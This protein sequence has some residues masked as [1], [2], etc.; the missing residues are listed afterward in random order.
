MRPSVWLPLSKP[1]QPVSGETLY[2]WENLKCHSSICTR[3]TASFPPSAVPPSHSTP[4]IFFTLFLFQSL[5]VPPPPPT[6]LPI[7]SQPLTSIKFLMAHF[8]LTLCFSAVVQ[9]LSLQLPLYQSVALDDLPHFPFYF[10]PQK[11]TVVVILSLQQIDKYVHIYSNEA[12]V[13]RTSL[14]AW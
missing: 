10:S 7:F 8:L 6:I 5:S 4:V 13:Y 1:R 12:T 2:C 14:I 3:S 11:E 9:G